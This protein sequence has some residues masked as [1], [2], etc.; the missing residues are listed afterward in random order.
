MK[1]NER[2]WKKGSYIIDLI[3]LDVQEFGKKVP[4]PLQE[5][6]LEKKVL[7]SR[8]SAHVCFFF[9]FLP[10]PIPFRKTQRERERGA[11]ICV[12]Q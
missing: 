12:E 8:L 4:P 7:A 5:Q 6:I 1:W 2:I 11:L 10:Y 9:S 3:Y